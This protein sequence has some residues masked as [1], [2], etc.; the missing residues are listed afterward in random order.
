MQR[1][2]HPGPDDLFRIERATV[3]NLGDEQG[4]PRGQAAAFSEWDLL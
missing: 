2:P 3:W 1:F 4:E